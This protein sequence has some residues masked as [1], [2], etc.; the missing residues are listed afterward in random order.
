MLHLL[1]GR[2]GSG[3]TTKIRA[4]LKET[5]IEQT[6][7]LLV[8]EQ[9]S[10]QNERA[11]LRLLGAKGAQRVQVLSFTRLADRVFRRYG[12]AAGRRLDDGGRNA[13]MSLALE[14]VK[15]QLDFY[16]KNADSVELISLLLSVEAE[17]KMCGVTPCDLLQM[18]VNG[19]SRLSGTLQQKSRELS[20]ILEAYEALVA[21]SFIDPLDDLTRLKL[22]LEQHAYFKGCV[23]AV[24]AF[25]S[26]TVQEYQIL[27]LILEQADE[28]YVS[29]CTDTLDDPEKGM[30]LFSLVR[31]TGNSL[32][33]L[34]KERGVRVATPVVLDAGKR[35]HAKGIAALERGA[36]RTVRGDRKPAEGV[37]L[38]EAR[39]LYDESEFT[40]AEIRELVMDAGYRYR[41]FAVIV[42]TPDAY[43][44]ILDAALERREIPYFM[45]KPQ[46][47][48]A[49]PLMRLVLSA[50]QVIRSGFASSDLF[51]YL[52]TGLTGLTVE[53]I[54]SLE[55]YTFL[56]SL[57]GKKW[58]EKW[59][60]HP[61]GF[62][63][64][65]TEKDR[66]ALA[67]LNE[68][69]AA[70]VEP[71][72]RFA[73]RIADADGEQM[74]AAVYQ[75]LEEIGVSEHLKGLA[76][77]LADAG[78]TELAERQLRLWDV[79]MQI[80]DQSALVLGGAVLRHTR[81]AEL[82]RLMILANDVASIP[83]ELDA[84]TV[85]AADRI[86]TH[87]PKVVFLLGASQEDFPLTPGSGGVFS[88]SE[89]RELIA[90]GLPLNDTLEGVAVQER[91]L[92][93]AAMS[94]ASERLFISFPAS[95]PEGEAK[96]ASV[97]VTEAQAILKDVPVHTQ[98]SL[99]LSFFANAEQSALAL[100]AQRWREQTPASAS[101]K[102]LFAEKEA[103]APRT[104]ALERVSHRRPA[105]F[106]DAQKAFDLFGASMH[107]SATQIEKF[108][109]CRF[110]YFCRFGLHA[111]ERRTAEL[112]ALE[113]GSL[114]HYLLEHL[115]RDL[116][117]ER[118]QK[119]DAPDLKKE[120]D[121][122]LN[123]YAETKMGGLQSKTPRF[124]Y[125]VARL[126]ESAAVIVRHIAE[127]LC[128]S[129]FQPVD[130]ELPI[131]T[132]EVPP[133]TVSLPD[134]GEVRVDGKVDRV[135][136]YRKKGVQYLRV[137][138]YK[139]GKKEFKLSDVIY[140][141]NM[142][143]L[144]YLAALCEN[145]G[146]RYGMQPGPAGILYMPASRPSLSA[147]RDASP[148]KVAAEE[149][150]KLR[151]NGLLVDD[152][153]VIEAMEQKAEGKY[154]PVA[155]KNGAPAKRDS[156]VSPK[157]MN[158]IMRHAKELVAQMALELHKGKIAAVPLNGDT[159][160]CEWCP[161]FAV[162]GHEQEDA[163]RPMT[164]WDRDAAVAELTQDAKGGD[165]D[166]NA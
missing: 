138:D 132:E 153:S 109:L 130:F 79:L 157:E 38:Y 152:A 137:I 126:S 17:L 40:A 62:V 30:G 10:F 155:L 124:A 42:R 70:V 11:M 51:S 141:V 92:A 84:V 61:K 146:T 8:P 29:L 65:W 136:L 2:A 89:R 33:R 53:E 120:I 45:D 101:L 57:S 142:Q 63:E 95:G 85:G 66:N 59:T 148:D 52:K 25:Q 12:G 80:L 50:F 160:A 78:K 34:A 139:T 144:I 96:R 127:E 1:L 90:L 115:F 156:V 24:D 129:E 36:F 69:R 159:D 7:V 82:L 91:F 105:A 76:A 145:A 22:L 131:G 35:F 88:D 41:D 5:P 18:A 31:R 122:L 83:E 163:A 143:M 128:Q 147:A 150:K 6:P 93:Y 3:K 99:P 20:L 106:E 151:M 108:Y 121:R 112:D 111:K 58:R 113:Y 68:S 118:L 110:Q 107:V 164:K 87:E 39:D 47:I 116:G 71:L 67:S 165:G 60:E 86:R 23:V 154:I 54:S 14:Q 161:Y 100:A 81:Y 44:E 72:L 46:R 48:D 21:Q 102:Q 77:Q 43:R 117:A 74:A 103:Y 4:L 158:A 28:V 97:I 125:L 19:Q 27:S 119:L 49:E 134:G 149:A 166:G 55:N 56:W 135:D 98:F 26:F 15:D 123:Q 133:L 75:L 114:M 13:F 37:A 140:G 162:C 9:S 73:E 104:A 64:E 94:A 16:R 32:V